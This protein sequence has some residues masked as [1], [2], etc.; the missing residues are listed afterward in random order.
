MSAERLCDLHAKMARGSVE[1]DSLVH[2]GREWL[3]SAPVLEASVLSGST[4]DRCGPTRFESRFHQRIAF[5]LWAGLL[6]LFTHSNT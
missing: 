4:A 5:T 6:S 1:R 3:A 2:K